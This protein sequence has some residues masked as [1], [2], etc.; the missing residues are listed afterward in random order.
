MATFTPQL[1]VP[2]TTD[3]WYIRLSAGGYSPCIE[4]KPLRHKGSALANCVGYAWGRVAFL[5]NDKKCNIGVPASRLKAGKYNPTSAQYWI[6][7]ANGRTVSKTTPKLGAVMVWKHTNSTSGH[8]GVVEKIDE[9]NKQ[10]TVSM[11]GYGSSGYTFR[12]EVLPFNGARK[13]CTFLGYIYPKADFTPAPA[14]TLKKG[15]KV[16]II[17]NGN[18]RKDG[19]GKTSKGI[20]YKRYIL[21][22]YSGQAY[23]Y[24]VGNKLGV[25]TGYY[26]ASALKKI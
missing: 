22:V 21:A 11:S 15:D 13:N 1:T 6:S 25:T 20:G 26:K 17:A 12:T 10:V 8:L 3:K 19:K 16:Q 23:P 18:A 5:E 7:Y 24:K 2:S 9:A 14:N 4:G